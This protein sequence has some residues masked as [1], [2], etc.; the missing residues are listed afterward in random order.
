MKEI[1]AVATSTK[2]SKMEIQTIEQARNRDL[3]KG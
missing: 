2:A 3:S 1:A